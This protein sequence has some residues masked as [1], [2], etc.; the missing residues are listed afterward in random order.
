L[1]AIDA[2][3]VDAELDVELHQPPRIV[4]AP[5]ARQL[6]AQSLDRRFSLGENVDDVDARAGRD[7]AEQR[8]H[9]TRRFLR[10]GIDAM[11]TP[12]GAG[13]EEPFAA[14]RDFTAR[15]DGRLGPLGRW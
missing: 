11:L 14:P 15:D 10:A 6:N 3:A 9:R 4:A 7:G 12:R 8:F 13:V 1:L 5:L 2:D